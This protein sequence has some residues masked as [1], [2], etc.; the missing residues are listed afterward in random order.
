MTHSVES[1]VQIRTV[2]TQHIIILPTIVG[3]LEK[4]NPIQ[5]LIPDTKHSQCMMTMMMMTK[6]MMMI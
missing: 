6:M 1:S 5:I 2:E 3:T 4:N